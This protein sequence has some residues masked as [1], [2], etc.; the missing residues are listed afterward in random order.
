TPSCRFD[1]P[2]Q[3]VPQTSVDSPDES[4]RVLFQ[5]L[6]RDNPVVMFSLEWCEFCWTLRKFFDAAAIPYRSI[7]LDSVKYQEDDLGVKLRSA[8]RERTGQPTIPQVFLGGEH[9][10]G[11]TDVIKAH[12]TGELQRRLAQCSIPNNGL[13]TISPEQFL[14][15]WVQSA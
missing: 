2:V 1:A 12:A 7:D 4:V 8:I 14:P 9:I 10:G 13:E 3:A 11:C 6:V 5:R 15:N